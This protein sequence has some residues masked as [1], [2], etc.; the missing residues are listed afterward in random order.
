MPGGAAQTVVELS[1]DADDV[2]VLA[3]PAAFR[4]V[5]RW[6]RHFEQLSD[7]DV[8]ALLRGAARGSGHA[9]GSGGLA[10]GPGEGQ[11]PDP[12]S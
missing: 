7:T 10:S 11:E 8:L 2:V 3:A 12:R 1:A 6:Y 5:G 9:A 4:A